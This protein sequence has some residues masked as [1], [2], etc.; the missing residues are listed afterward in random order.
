M[1]EREVKRM[2]KIVERA[3]QTVATLR[4]ENAELAAAQY[5][6]G[7]TGRDHR[8]ASGDSPILSVWAWRNAS[9]LSATT[10]S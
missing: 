3:E 1:S 6:D 10:G 5:P 9:S 7:A 8:H 4:E 2:K